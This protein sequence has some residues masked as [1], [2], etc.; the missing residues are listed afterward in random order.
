MRT[1]ARAERRFCRFDRGPRSCRR[2]SP[3]PSRRR[4]ECR[5]RSGACPGRVDASAR[6]ALAMR[7][8]RPARPTK[9][10]AKNDPN[11][12]GNSVTIATFMFLTGL[13]SARRASQHD[14]SRR[15]VDT[16]Q[17]RLRQ[18]L[19]G[20]LPSLD[21]APRHR[22]WGARRCPSLPRTSPSGPVTFAPTR[23]NQIYSPGSS[24]GSTL[25]AT[26]TVGPCS[27]SAAL[28]SVDSAQ[29]HEVG[30]R[31]RARALDR[32]RRRW[33]F[34]VSQSSVT[35]SSASLDSQCGT[36]RSSPVNAVSLADAP[37]FEARLGFGRAHPT[38]S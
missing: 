12:S 4:T 14:A 13:Q 8:T 28:R 9:L 24:G 18:R 5:P 33:P 30:A 31:Y 21:A 27:A 16:L 32:E 7:S 34:A 37:D 10:S 29:L 36:M 35:R 22:P 20:A 3:C 1:R 26:L 23:S 15:D 6:G 2:A 17:P 38:S 19:L 11:S 25:R